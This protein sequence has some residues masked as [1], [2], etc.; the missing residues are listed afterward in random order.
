MKRIGHLYE[1][2]CSFQNLF[3]AFKKAFRGKRTD[4]VA[5]TFCFNLERELLALQEEL[6]QKTYCPQK[7]HYFTIVDPKKREISV[8]SFRDRVVH[9]A[10]CNILEPIFEK[11]FI[12]DSYACRVQKGTHRAI[13]RAQDFSRRNEFFLQGDIKK[14]FDNI[15]HE[16]MM[17]II[18]AKIKD[19]KVLW[20]CAKILENSAISRHTPELSEGKGIP[21]G[22]L[23][24]Q[25]F[26]NVYLNRFDHF[27]QEEL[28][29]HCYIRYMDDFILF[30]QDKK[31]LKDNLERLESYLQEELHLELKPESFQI[32]KTASGFNFLGF[33]VFPNLIRIKRAN[34]KRFR[35][36]MDQRQKE[37]EQGKISIDSLVMSL[38]SV[39][40]HMGLAQSYRLRERLLFG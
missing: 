10:L 32:R 19:Q 39:V 5:A 27:I 2:L 38:Q 30:H 36:R 25:F 28:R 4:Q 35:Q 33:R 12:Y 16:I 17:K 31:R 37:Y 8:A 20:L 11:T 23:T 7:Y 1:R 14:Y 29:G 18:E 15:N 6:R 24:S 22:N 26:A 40:G 9:H 3:L 13:K 34:V 21:I